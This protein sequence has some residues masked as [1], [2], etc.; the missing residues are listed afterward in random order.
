MIQLNRQIRAGLIHDLDRVSAYFGLN[1]LV[2]LTVSQIAQDEQGNQ[3][4]TPYGDE[5]FFT[6][7]DIH[8]QTDLSQESESILYYFLRVN[9][10]LR[11]LH[12][13]M[14]CHTVTI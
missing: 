1:R 6:Y 3:A 11:P 7:P 14:L 10:A 13:P 8:P 9:H 5:Q 4:K 2:G 12:Q